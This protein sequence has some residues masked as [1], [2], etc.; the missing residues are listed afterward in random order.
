MK[1]ET[2]ARKAAQ[3]LAKELQLKNDKLRLRGAKKG[4]FDGKELEEIQVS[5]QLPVL[6]PKPEVVFLVIKQCVFSETISSRSTKRTRRK[7]CPSFTIFSS[8][9]FSKWETGTNS[10]RKSATWKTCFIQA[11][12]RFGIWVVCIQIWKFKWII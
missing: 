10:K 11:H 2:D 7:T 3:K 8:T 4:K 5:Y 9:K 12:C 6:S 1:L